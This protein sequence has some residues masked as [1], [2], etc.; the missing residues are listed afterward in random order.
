MSKLSSLSVVPVSF[1]TYSFS[2]ELN[3]KKWLDL[4]A[5]SS[6][7]HLLRI[8]TEFAHINASFRIFS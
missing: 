4:K 1:F 8:V 5:T 7:F 2:F 6:E 3:T